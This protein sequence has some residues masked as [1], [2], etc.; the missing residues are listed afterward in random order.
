VNE[1]EISMKKYL[2]VALAAC[3][4]LGA[5]TGCQAT[6][7]E[8]S[9]T[10]TSSN[11]P[12]TAC[13][14]SEPK[15]IDPAI[16]QAV[17]GSSYIVH[18]FEG[19]T[20]MDKNNKIVAGVAADPKISAD[21]LT[22]TYT[23]RS[24]AKWSDG[25]AVKAGD[26]VYAWQRAVNPVTASA[27]AYQL[28]YIKNAQEINAQAVDKSGN[29][30]K[31][32]FGADG[33]PVQD[34]DGNYTADANGKYVSANAD[35]TPTWLNDLGVKATDDHTLV[36]TLAGPCAYF[37]QITA[38]PTLYPVRK[39]IVDKNPDTWATDP[40]TF[41]GD[42]PYTITEWD[43]NSKIVMKKNANYYAKDQIVSNEIDWLLM[44][45]D[46]SILAAYKNGQIQLSDN[47]P[48]AE[49]PALVKSG[50]CKVYPNLGT[51]YIDFN[52]TKAP[53]NNLK[54]REA[55]NLAYD[56]EYLT[57]TAVQGG[58][59][60]AAAWV[61]TGIPD[62][63]TGS[64]FRVVGKDYFTTSTSSYAANVKK[65]QQL[66]SEAGYPGGKGFPTVEYKYNTT[67]LH[68]A[69]A[70][71]LQQEWKK[72]L[73]VNVTLV[74]EEWAVL[75]ADRNNKNYQIARDGWLGDYVDPMTFVDVFT[76]KSG[77]NSTG[78]ANADYD[79]LVDAAKKSNDVKTRMTDMHKA[80]DILMANMPMSPVMY[81]SDPDLVSSKLSGYVHS[82]LG[83][84]Y[85]MWASVK[86]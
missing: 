67:T 35:G 39:D 26:F 75:Q 50:D 14:G 28:N 29:P 71:Y 12:I 36:V 42:G 68:K 7:K 19:L 70:E 51:Y 8:T 6:P 62:A 58:Y 46:N 9:S 52:N 79:K 65:A 69:V 17:D 82:T 54:V 21:G 48:T 47:M 57:S 43:H 49:I 63:T 18:T 33:K 60:P 53:F 56:R 81:Y 27:Y 11:V 59:K 13:I 23:I 30:E 38:F 74:D 80:E 2:A 32:K 61:P 31:V 78:F 55:F 45:A 44:D 86:S 5:L 64:D 20:K 77:N 1:E 24:D 4:I 15:S 37:P 40:K 76:S 72:N 10:T 66:L 34:K 73:G 25:V 41:I 3:S 22:Y 85:L 83:Y 84:K 16:N